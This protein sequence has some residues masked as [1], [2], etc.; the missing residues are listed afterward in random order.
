MYVADMAY[1]LRDVNEAAKVIHD[2]HF[3]GLFPRTVWSE[4]VSAAASD[5]SWS[6]SRTSDTEHEVFLELRAASCELPRRRRGM[7]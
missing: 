4:P 3:M 5:L 7:A 1:L 6:P 2:R